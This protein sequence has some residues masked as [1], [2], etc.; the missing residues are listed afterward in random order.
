MR[1]ISLHSILVAAVVIAA[2]GGS[3][4]AQTAEGDQTTGD[5][6]TDDTADKTE[7]QEPQVPPKIT[8]EGAVVAPSPAGI[9][10]DKAQFA[11]ADCVAMLEF[12]PVRVIRIGDIWKPLTLLAIG[13]G[14]AALLRD[15]T[16]RCHWCDVDAVGGDRL[17]SL[18]NWGLKFRWGSGGSGTSTANALSWATLVSSAV[19]PAYFA[20]RTSEGGR[21]MR[22]FAIIS[23]AAFGADAL[24]SLVKVAAARERPYSYRL[25]KSGD[26]GPR[27]GAAYRSFFSGHTSVAFAATMVGSR[28]MDLYPDVIEGKSTGNR[29]LKRWV[30]WT[31]PVLTAY[32]RIASDK[33]FITDV[34]VGAAAGFLVGGYVAAHVKPGVP[35]E[36]RAGPVASV[37]FMPTMVSVG[38][39][40]APGVSVTW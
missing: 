4:R 33:H 27:P 2:P 32:L 14:G 15:Q 36:K 18:D 37:T 25:T 5:Q 22:N 11:S 17:N 40:V 28:L 35:P 3:L 16:D 23:F 9:T 13:E 12:G 24:T 19:V 8:K 26:V 38:Q 21:F 31:S 20:G 29:R 30:L 1:L 7:G 6:A 10:C 39:S 34:G